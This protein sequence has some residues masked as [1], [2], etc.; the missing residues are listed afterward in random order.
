MIILLKDNNND[1]F[2][3]LYFLFFLIKLIISQIQLL[4]LIAAL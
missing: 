3:Y 2:E 1:L 4:L